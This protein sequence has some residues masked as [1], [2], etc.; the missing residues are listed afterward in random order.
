MTPV[1]PEGYTVHVSAMQTVFILLI[2]VLSWIFA[3]I[4]GF[5]I[6]S[7]IERKRAGQPIAGQIGAS[8]KK[9]GPE[10]AKR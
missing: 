2:A 6:G 1:A 5:A 10:T 7:E 9:S 4:M 3:L 8:R